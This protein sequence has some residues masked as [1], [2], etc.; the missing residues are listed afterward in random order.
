[1]KCNLTVE[2]SN[3]TRDLTILYN[4]L[5]GI[6]QFEDSFCISTTQNQFCQA[7]NN[8]DNQSYVDDLVCQDVR[9]EYCTMEWKILE[10]QGGAG[11]PDCAAYG[12]T[13]RLTCSDQFDVD[14]TGVACQPLCKEFS[15]NGESTTAAIIVLSGIANTA[16][17]I[18]GIFVLIVAFY[19]RDKM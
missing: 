11:L 2:E 10:L 19:R 8:C 17:T 15:Q 5:G 14:D 12:E 16:N 7:L 4:S 18:G 6:G 9:Q 13:D 1:M 3:C